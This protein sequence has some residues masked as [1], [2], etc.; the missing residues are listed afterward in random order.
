[1]VVVKAVLLE[2]VLMLVWLLGPWPRGEVR[3]FCA[4]IPVFNWNLVTPS[5]HCRLP[6]RLQLVI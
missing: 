6:L 3:Y 2:Q 1:V 4:A 5:Q